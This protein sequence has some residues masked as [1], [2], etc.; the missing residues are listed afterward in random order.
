MENLSLYHILNLVKIQKIVNYLFIL[1]FTYYLFID[2]FTMFIYLMHVG[3]LAHSWR[4]MHVFYSLAHYSRKNA[5]CQFE[6]NVNSMINII[7]LTYCAT[8]WRMNS[9]RNKP[10]VILLEQLVFQRNKWWWTVLHRTFNSF[11]DWSYAMGK[12]L[13]CLMKMG[14]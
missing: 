11:S 14:N 2:L 6:Y 13:T 10:L 7:R 9:L 12:L 8:S 1:L 5:K 3:M 4:C